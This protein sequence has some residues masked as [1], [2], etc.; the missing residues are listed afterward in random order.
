MSRNSITGDLARNQKEYESHW[1]S[2][3][4]RTW[5]YSTQGKVRRF[6]ALMRKHKLLERKGVAVFDHGFGLGLMLFCFNRTARI[7][8]VELSGSAVAAAKERAQR[9]GFAEIDLRAHDA[10]AP[11][12]SEWRENFD[13]VIS[14]H[15]LEHCQNPDLALRDLVTL[16]KPGGAVCLIV[17]I[18]E[19][20]GEDMNHFSWFTPGS[21]LEMALEVGLNRIETFTCDRLYDVITPLSFARQRGDTILLRSVSIAFNAL[22][23]MVPYGLL[24]VADRMLRVFGYRERQCFLLGQKSRASH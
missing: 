13:L 5:T 16:V 3:F 7:A 15:V 23:A 1:R 19:A 17:P 8:G 18:N 12:P 20:P 10:G 22:T 11:L 4:R 24:K 6:R 9:L 21:L 14:S 2:R